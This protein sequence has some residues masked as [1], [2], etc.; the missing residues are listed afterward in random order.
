MLLHDPEF[1]EMNDLIL[2]HEIRVRKMKDKH[3]W[4][5]KNLEEKFEIERR[6]DVER[7]GDF[8][9]GLEKLRNIDG[10]RYANLV[11][12]QKE[13]RAKLVAEHE[14]NIKNL[15]EKQSTTKTLPVKRD[16]V[17]AAA[18]IADS[19]QLLQGNITTIMVKLVDFINTYS[20]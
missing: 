6:K 14:L 20:Q 5:I 19:V 2:D 13:E 18:I 8:L 9:N 10:D 16:I 15:K 3:E 1:Q 17:V 11:D 4:E 12:E 7:L